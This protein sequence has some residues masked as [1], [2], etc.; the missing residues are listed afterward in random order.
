MK[1]NKIRIVFKN[2][3]VKIVERDNIRN[4]NSLID[5]MEQFNSGENVALLTL[6]SK[7]LGSSFSIDKNNIK[8]IEI[9][10]D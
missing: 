4:F 1:L 10:N 7:E 5:W 3:F 6:S 9:L 2:D 8:L